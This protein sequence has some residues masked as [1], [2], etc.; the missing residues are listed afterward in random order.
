MTAF[1]ANISIENWLK[2]LKKHLPK[3]PRHFWQTVGSIL[4]GCFQK[5]LAFF[6]VENAGLCIFKMRKQLTLFT[7]LFASIR[8]RYTTFSEFVV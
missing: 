3:A 4:G 1:F 2:N 6:N 5:N 7:M 8:G